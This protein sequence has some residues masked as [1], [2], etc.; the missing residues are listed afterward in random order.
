MIPTP[1]SERKARLRKHMRAA[2][3]GLAADE[4]ERLDDAING[5]VAGLAAHLA[6]RCV[7]AYLGFDGEPCLEPVL[8][9]FRRRGVTVLLPVIHADKSSIMQF[10]SW[11]GDRA[12]RP[13][14][15]GIPEP[16][17]GRLHR[18]EHCD[19][20]LA[21]LVA[22]DRRGNRLGMGAG[23][24]DRAFAALRAPGGPL[25]A[26]VGYGFQEV[27]AVPCDS[28]D[29]P[30]QAVVNERGW[31]IIDPGDRIRRSGGERR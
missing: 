1:L 16:A 14:R 21:P 15:F 3:A 13:N 22:W 12:L 2:R 9:Q 28:G 20:V 26:G 27:P 30:L 31:F 4:R 24:Y 29:Q 17:S 7:A 5:F 19:L 23:Y 8:K 6:A 10:R 11:R 18:L 25:R